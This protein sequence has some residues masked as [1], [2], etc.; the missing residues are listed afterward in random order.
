MVEVLSILGIAAIR[1][2]GNN[3][4]HWMVTSGEIAS[5]VSPMLQ[6]PPTMAATIVLLSIIQIIAVGT[7]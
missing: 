5:N 3:A 2:T 4:L 1:G 6:F 7:Q